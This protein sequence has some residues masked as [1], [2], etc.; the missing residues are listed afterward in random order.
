MCAAL[1][2]FAVVVAF[3]LLAGRSSTVIKVVATDGTGA[4]QVP[5]MAVTIRDGDRPAIGES[6]LLDAAGSYVPQRSLRNQVVCLTPGPGWTISDPHTD[7]QGCT[8]TPI[9]D[10]NTDV[11]FTLTKSPGGGP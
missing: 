10:P 5:G 9:T 3:G 6:G 8:T 2:A 11:V 1:V 7:E 4:Q